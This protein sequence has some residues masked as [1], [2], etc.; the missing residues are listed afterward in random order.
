MI[1]SGK[2][3]QAEKSFLESISLS[4]Q[5]KDDIP[6]AQSLISLGDVYLEKKMDAEAAQVIDKGVAIFLGKP[7]LINK[8]L[9]WIRI[10]GN[11][12]FNQKI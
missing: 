4:Q 3:E 9:T 7:N 8:Q 6:Y 1:N 2:L 10:A 12:Y 11:T 5:L